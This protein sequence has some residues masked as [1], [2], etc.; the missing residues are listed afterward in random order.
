[1]HPAL[2]ACVPLA[3]L[4]L[5]ACAPSHAPDQAP[6]PAAAPQP[7]AKAVSQPPALA[8]IAPK[9]EKCTNQPRTDDNDLHPAVPTCWMAWA[10]KPRNRNA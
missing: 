9:E 4:V 5:A 2:R 8:V 7:P 6:K 1:M 3:L 10:G